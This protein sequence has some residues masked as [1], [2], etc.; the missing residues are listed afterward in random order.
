M[1][2]FD[3]RCLGDEACPDD[4]KF[5]FTWTLPAVIQLSLVLSG[6]SVWAIFGPENT[7]IPAMMAPVGVIGRHYHVHQPPLSLSFFFSV[8]FAGLLSLFLISLLIVS[9]SASFF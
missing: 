1:E 3:T 2:W 7:T 9:F 5:W 4:T 6:D 8:L